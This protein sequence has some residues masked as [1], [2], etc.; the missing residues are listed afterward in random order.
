MDLTQNG[1]GEGTEVTGQTPVSVGQLLLPPLEAVGSNGNGGGSNTYT[2]KVETSIGT[3]DNVSLTFGDSNASGK[4]PLQAGMSHVVTLNIGD[5][6][7]GITSVTVQAW[8]SVTV[9]GTLDAD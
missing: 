8:A 5:H 7:L 6:E 1:A 2:L 9:D 4:N 3:F